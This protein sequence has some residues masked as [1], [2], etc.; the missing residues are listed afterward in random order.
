M[1]TWRCGGVFL[2]L[3]DVVQDVSVELLK[4]SDGFALVTVYVCVCVWSCLEDE[5]CV[6]LCVIEA[7]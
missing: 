7:G 3:Q 4:A 1:Q 2:K 6:C 5:V